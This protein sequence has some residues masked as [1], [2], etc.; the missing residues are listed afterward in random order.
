[1]ICNTLT[2]ASVHC[3]TNLKIFLSRRGILLWG[4]RGGLCWL[5][6]IWIRYQI[7]R[8]ST[9]N[10]VSWSSSLTSGSALIYVTSLHVVLPYHIPCQV[11]TNGKFSSNLDKL[12]Y[13]LWSYLLFQLRASFLTHLRVRLLGRSNF[14]QWVLLLIGIFRF[15]KAGMNVVDLLGILPYFASLIISLVMTA[16]A[17]GQA[18]YQE[19]GIFFLMEIKKNK[20]WNFIEAN[21]SKYSL[22]Y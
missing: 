7:Y 15:L 13:V 19:N 17:Q 12:I 8:G 5:V 3:S 20:L 10:G 14:W 21:L 2:E 6:H 16:T 1:M 9:K 18:N 4:C 22:W 11:I